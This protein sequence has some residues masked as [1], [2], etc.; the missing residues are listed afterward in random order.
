MMGFVD[1]EARGRVASGVACLTWLALWGLTPGLRSDGL[2]SRFADGFS[3]QVLIECAVALL[4]ATALWWLRP[5]TTSR[6]FDRS[7]LR[8]LY[9]LPVAL[10]VLLPFHYTM[11]APV[12]VY[13]V[14]MTV[15]VLWQN[16]LT[17][18]LLQSF[19]RERLPAGVTIVLVALMFWLGHVVF[20]PGNFAPTHPSGVLA[21]LAILAMGLSFAWLRARTG[22]MHLLLSIHLAFYFVFA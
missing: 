16:Y 9:L 14:W 1:Q 12:G 4:V 22:T 10:A 18:G 15:S 19:L 8:W 5:R 20:L 17:F 3:T 7:R 2:G 21:G 11:A 13:L 6:L